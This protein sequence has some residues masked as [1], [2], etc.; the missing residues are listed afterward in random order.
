MWDLIIAA[1]WLLFLVGW[2]AAYFHA[3]QP[4]QGTLE[5]IKM[6]DRQPFTCLGDRGKLEKQDIWWLL[7]CG[8]L[9]LGT[10]IVLAMPLS[11]WGPMQLTNQ[12]AMP[13]L[14]VMGVYLLNRLLKGRPV[15]GAL[16]ALAVLIP[17]MDPA[18]GPA[19]LAAACFYGWMSSAADVPF[20]RAALWLVSFWLCIGVAAALAPACLWMLPFFGL[21]WLFTVIQ[22][23][24]K[25]YGWGRIVL[26]AFLCLVLLCGMIAV[27]L[28]FWTL[29]TGWLYWA[30]LPPALADGRLLN[31]IARLLPSVTGW[32]VQEAGLAMALDLAPRFIPLLAGLFAF[33]ALVIHAL[34][35][36]SVP[37]AFLAALSVGAFAVY[38]LGHSLILPAV[39]L[40]NTVYVA[41]LMWE[42]ERK[43]PAVLLPA[44][45]LALDIGNYLLR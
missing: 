22:R 19:I 1:V 13:V 7:G 36:R 28:V 39:C 2:F 5:W 37:A 8:I 40:A 15:L 34:R 35:R 14:G 42:R 9:S 4:K 29:Q 24:R 31:A 18:A 20:W 45:L 10:C 30:E 44:L 3:M 11:Q 43:L 26:N 21:L 17:S 38:V 25:G 32:L 27:C 6:Y 23:W 41:G 16:C 12:I 33:I